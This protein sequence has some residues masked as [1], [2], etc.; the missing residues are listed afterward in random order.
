MIM[1][2]GNSSGVVSHCCLVFVVKA[3]IMVPQTAEHLDLL[4]NTV[5]VVAGNVIAVT[6]SVGVIA[7]HVLVGDMDIAS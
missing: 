1:R 3:C 6:E 5:E 4:D 7:S 2:S